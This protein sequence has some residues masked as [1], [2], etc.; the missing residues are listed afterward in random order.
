ME[1]SPDVFLGTYL[2]AAGD[3]VIA[4]MIA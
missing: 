2:G 1:Q 4:E 3:P